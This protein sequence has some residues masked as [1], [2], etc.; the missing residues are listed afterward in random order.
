MSHLFLLFHGV[1]GSA[2]DLA[3][4]ARWLAA[5]QPDATVVAVDAPDRSDLGAGRQWFSVRG[6]TEENRPARVAATLARF[7]E[8]VRQRQAQ[9][10]LGAE[11]TTL[12]GFSQG[13]IM[14][15]EAAL[16]PQPVA[17]RVIALSGR[18]SRLPAVLPGPVRFHFLHGDADTVIPV[19][20]A[21]A[22]TDAVRVAG[23]DASL[24]VLVGVGHGIAPATLAALE[25][26][27]R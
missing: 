20:H 14:A 15:L 27:S 10:G 25:R 1:A 2:A 5:R 18:F 6:V 16:Q 21:R 12:V 13:A 23:G 19:E 7:E 11:R 4:L 17:Q 24:D 22:G 26:V 3:P 8:A 9:A